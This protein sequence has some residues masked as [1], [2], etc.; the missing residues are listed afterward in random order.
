MNHFLGGLFAPRAIWT[1]RAKMRTTISRASQRRRRE[2]GITLVDVMFGAIIIGVM[3]VGLYVGFSQG[4][5]VIQL[6]RE[7]LRATQI[8]QEKME[9]VRLYTWDQVRNPGFIP[10]TFTAPFYAIAEQSEG[11]I[12]SGRLTIANAPVA[13]SYANDLRLVTVEVT[14]NSGNVLRRRDMQSMIS[15]YG[16][17]NYIY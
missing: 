11:L 16:L 8:L 13:E 12:Y 6:S 1:E 4:F 15:R 9:T 3:V 14:W 7:N 17:H 5:A 2:S 10:S